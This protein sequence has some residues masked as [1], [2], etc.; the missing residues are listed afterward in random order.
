MKMLQ[1]I[2][3]QIRLDNKLSQENI[4]ADLNMSLTG[5]AKIERGE[6]DVNY[7]RLQHIASYY[8]LDVLQLLSYGTTVSIDK[9]DSFKEEE[10]THLKEIIS[11][12][13]KK[14]ELLKDVK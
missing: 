4:A 9:K 2:L 12:L 13:E 1:E 5:Y 8:N 11:L 3:R 6:T 14:I 7:S 10:I